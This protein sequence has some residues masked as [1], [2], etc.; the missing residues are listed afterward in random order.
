MLNGLAFGVFYALAAFPLAALAERT[1]RRRVIAGSVAA[2]SAFTALLALSQGFWSLFGGRLLV[3]VGEAGSTPAAQ[4]M[5]AAH[6]SPARRPG[7]F[8]AY[9]TGG[10]VGLVLAFAAGGALV[11]AVGWRLT[12]ACL[13][14][15][16]LLLAAAVALWLPR[17]PAAAS[18]GM[19]GGAGFALLRHPVVRQIVAFTAS[20]SLVSYGQLGWAQSF[21][22]RS[23]GLSP[24]QAGLAL[25]GIIGGGTILGALAGA[26]VVEARAAICAWVGSG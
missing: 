18:G 3:G 2:W 24:A 8:A 22:I 15:P 5:I 25:S 14:L 21:Y 6:F 16:G 7:A 10:Y 17:E 11:Q 23:F 26:R 13:G 12:F 20:A 19:A 4:S 1:G 9:Q